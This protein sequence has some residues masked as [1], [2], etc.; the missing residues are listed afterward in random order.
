ME[1]FNEKTN[2]K[3]PPLPTLPSSHLGLQI[4]NNDS[5]T[6]RLA[7]PS[8]QINGDVDKA[9]GV[10]PTPEESNM[11]QK[12]LKRLLASRQ[13]SQRY[14]QKQASYVEQ[15]ENELKALQTEVAIKAPRV[16]FADQRNMLLRA[17]NNTMRQ[18][19]D[20]KSGEYMYKRAEH[21]LLKGEKDSLLQLYEATRQ[22]RAAEAF[23]PPNYHQMTNLS[24]NQPGLG[25]GV[26]YQFN[27]PASPIDTLVLKQTT[28]D[29]NQHAAGQSFVDMMN[30]ADT[31]NMS[32]NNNG[33]NNII[34]MNDHM[35]M[36]PLEMINNDFDESDQQNPDGSANKFM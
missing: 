14:R 13:Y 30:N 9:K 17:E 18:M 20:A 15:L 34:D 11:D 8:Y 3:M 33:M 28:D 22:Q 5:I 27:Q 23:R 32:M 24:L 12:K 19:V 10:A 4:S 1:G 16:K 2:M 36:N 7:P 29:L 25:F 6:I 35:D 31:Y 21:D 26:A